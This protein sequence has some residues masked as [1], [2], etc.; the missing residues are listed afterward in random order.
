MIIA[1]HPDAG[2][3]LMKMKYAAVSK[4]VLPSENEAGINFLLKSSF[5]EYSRGTRMYLG[6]RIQWHPEMLYSRIGGNL[7]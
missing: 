3:V 6:K 2:I 4:A 1:D 7:K 5:Q